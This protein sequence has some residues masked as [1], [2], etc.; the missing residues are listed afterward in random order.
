MGFDE[1][2]MWLGTCSLSETDA[3]GSLSAGK[4]KAASKWFLRHE[5]GCLKIEDGSPIYGHFIW[6]MDEPNDD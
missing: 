2:A 5:W 3:D 4:K 6:N 1:E